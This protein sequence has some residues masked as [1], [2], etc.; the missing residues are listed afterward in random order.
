MTGYR[1]LDRRYGILINT[2][3]RFG[4]W[5]RMCQMMEIEFKKQHDVRTEGSTRT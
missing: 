5:S 4:D 1:P 3:F 2:L